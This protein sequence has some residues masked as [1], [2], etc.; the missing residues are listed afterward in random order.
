VGTVRIAPLHAIKGQE[1]HQ[2]ILQPEVDGRMLDSRV[3]QKAEPA[4]RESGADS[5]GDA[6]APREVLLVNN[7]IFA[8][9]CLDR[10]L[11]RQACRA[12]AEHAAVID[13][14]AVRPVARGPVK[15]LADVGDRHLNGVLRGK[16]GLPAQPRVHDVALSVDDRV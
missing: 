14:K 11:S 2:S 6:V 9:L 7:T 3:G 12:F 8:A 10:H 15:V 4:I 16:A 5:F 13:A 1:R